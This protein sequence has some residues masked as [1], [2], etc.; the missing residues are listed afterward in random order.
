MEATE[1]ELLEGP[2]KIEFLLEREGRVEAGFGAV[3]PLEGACCLLA[4][5][6]AL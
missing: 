6:G 5:R 1:D 2:Y 4:G 3:A